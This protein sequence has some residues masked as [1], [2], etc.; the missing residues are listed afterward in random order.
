[1]RRVYQKWV[2]SHCFGDV[3]MRSEDNA[4]SVGAAAPVPAFLPN[5]SMWF[6]IF[7]QLT[8]FLNVNSVIDGFASK[9]EKAKA[10]SYCR[11][12]KGSPVAWGAPFTLDDSFEMVTLPG[13]LRSYT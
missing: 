12:G 5:S 13:Q 4:Q 7:N 10:D 2:T 11:G 1:K 9:T 6:T 3:T 8:N